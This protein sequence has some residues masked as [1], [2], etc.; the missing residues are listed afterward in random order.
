[1]RG[2]TIIAAMFVA[3]GAGFLD[4]TD[5]DHMF[6]AFLNGVIGTALITYGLHYLTKKEKS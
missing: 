6:F 4:G 5:A 2:E 1:M 3:S